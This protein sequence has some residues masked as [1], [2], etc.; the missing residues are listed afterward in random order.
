MTDITPSRLGLSG[1]TGADDALF[2]KQFSGEVMTAFSEVNV[3]M[4]RHLV[5]TITN[6]KSAQ[7][8]ATWK[9]DAYYHVPG[10]EL[11]GQS[12][13]HG[14]RVITIDDLLV[15]P[16]FVA[17]IDEA[18]NHY[19]VRSIYTNECGYALA[20]QADKNVLQTAVLAARAS[21]TITGGI[22]GSTLAVGPDIVTNANG[23]L[24]NALYLA[25]QTLDEKDVPE[26]G[27]FAVFKPAQY[28]KLVLDDKAINRDFTA[29]NGD[30]RTGKVFDIAGVQIVKSNHLPTSAIAA[31]A[32]SANVPTGVTPQIGPRPL[33]KYAGDFSNTAGLVMHAN[34]VGTVKLMDLS[35][36]GEYLI[37]R[38]GTLIV[39][40][41][42]MG[43]GI[44]RPE[45]AVE[46]SK[47]A[48]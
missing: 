14:E 43:H 39:A 42:A 9:A 17:Q 44:L 4:E 33:G 34:A 8:P 48:T 2:L 45:C 18:K 19:D 7:F 13:K 37:T 38:Q 25:A 35:V 26:Q 5:R 15:S 36:E 22:G 40:K 31:P 41:Y 24:V 27:R 23:A 32:G 28:Y 1:G 46:L 16:V 21:A 12:I 47:S 29:G 6:G 10:T 3:M 30:I 20:N 11:Q